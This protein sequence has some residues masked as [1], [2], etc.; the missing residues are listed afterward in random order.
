MRKDAKRIKDIDG[1]SQILLDLKPDRCDSDVFIKQKMDVTE[2]V[3]YIEKKKKKGEDITYFHAF[4]TAIAK[5]LYNRPKLNRFIANRHVYEH[6]DVVIGFIIHVFFAQILFV[7]THLKKSL[8]NLHF[9]ERPFGKSFSMFFCN[10]FY[11][12]KYFV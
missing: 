6:N 5:V 10:S 7:S 12:R 3:K 1:L 4:V 9:R 11:F 2:L 8:L